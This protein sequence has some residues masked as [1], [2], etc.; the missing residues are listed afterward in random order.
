MITV[1]S[2][3]TMYVSSLNEGNDL[4]ITNQTGA[5]EAYVFTSDQS[6][7]L[8]FTFTDAAGSTVT[9]NYTGVSLQRGKTVEINLNQDIDFSKNG[10]FTHEGFVSGGEAIE[11]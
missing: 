4:V 9:Q 8:T 10:N 7:T 11:F 1:H 5:I 2:D 3:G 6:Q